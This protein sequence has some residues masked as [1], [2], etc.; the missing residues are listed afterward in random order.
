[1]PVGDTCRR[2][3]LVEVVV[4]HDIHIGALFVG[5]VDRPFAVRS[6]VTGIDHVAVETIGDDIVAFDQF[7]CAGARQQVFSGSSG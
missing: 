6:P 1:M 7:R 2:D 3:D 4:D 5:V